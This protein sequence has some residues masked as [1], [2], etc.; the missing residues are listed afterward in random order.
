MNEART[1]YDTMADQRET[2]LRMMT[3]EELHLRL[4]EDQA[5]FQ[6]LSRQAEV[7]RYEKEQ[8]QKIMEELIREKGG[9]AVYFPDIGGA[10]RDGVLLTLLYG[11]EFESRK[12]SLNPKF[13]AAV[14]ADIIAAS[15][16]EEEEAK[17]LKTRFMRIA[18]EEADR[19]RLKQGVKPDHDE[20]EADF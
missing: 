9:A 5:K 17:R 14:S 20:D 8:S 4:T 2:E 13:A 16:K 6:E 1:E 3:A 10:S 12:V 7:A 15:T 11:R 18:P 19:R